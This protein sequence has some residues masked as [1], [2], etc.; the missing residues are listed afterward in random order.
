M[1]HIQAERGSLQNS[2]L[3]NSYIQVTA[4]FEMEIKRLDRLEDIEQV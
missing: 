4:L 2:E 1:V 3:F